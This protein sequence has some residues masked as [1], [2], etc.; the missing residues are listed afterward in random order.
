MSDVWVHVGVTLCAA[1]VVVS[2]GM[3]D[4]GALDAWRRHAGGRRDSHT[5]TPQGTLTLTRSG[6]VVCEKL[7]DVGCAHGM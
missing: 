5:H 4:A 1:C 2:C 6:Y 3:R 7:R